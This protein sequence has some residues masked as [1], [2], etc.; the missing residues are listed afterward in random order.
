MLTPVREPF[1]S[2]HYFGDTRPFQP[3]GEQLRNPGMP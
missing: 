1:L 3:L 2:G